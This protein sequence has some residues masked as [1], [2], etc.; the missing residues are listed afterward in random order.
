MTEF[1]EAVENRK[2]MIEAEKWASECDWLQVH[3][4]KTMWYDDRPEDTDESSVMDKAYKSG[5]IAR[6]ILKTGEKVYFGKPLKG[7]ELLNA[8][9]RKG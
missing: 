1:T 8:Y 9:L 7:E 3:K 6:T 5:I 2:Q 4:L